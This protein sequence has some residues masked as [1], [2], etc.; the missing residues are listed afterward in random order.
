ML[1]PRENAGKKKKGFLSLSKRG[2]ARLN[3]AEFPAPLIWG[4]GSP[5]KGPMVWAD[6]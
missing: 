4:G 3:T 5:R 6:F 1:F 2:A